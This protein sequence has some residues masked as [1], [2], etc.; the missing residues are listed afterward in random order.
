[1]FVHKF[2]R[3]AALACFAVL[4]PAKPIAASSTEPSRIPPGQRF[5]K[6]ASWLPYTPPMFRSPRRPPAREISRFRR[7]RS[8]PTSARR[9]AR[10]QGGRPQRR[11]GHRGQHGDRQRATGGRRRYR[12]GTGSSHARTA[13]DLD[14]QS[15]HGRLQQDGGRAAAGSGWRDARRLRPGADHAGGQQP[16]DDTFNV[17]GG[18]GGAYGATLDGVSF[19]PAVSTRCSGPTSTR[20]RSTPSPSSP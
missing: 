9:K 11:D 10:V 8:E 20:L 6:R 16:G 15:I 2:F 1:M 13:A 7:C 19:S 3:L 12:I 17:G 4:L 5:R 18:Q 14:R